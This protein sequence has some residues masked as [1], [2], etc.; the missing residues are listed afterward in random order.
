MRLFSNNHMNIKFISFPRWQRNKIDKYEV[1][2]SVT[3]S[4]HKVAE[5]IVPNLTLVI[6]KMQT[7]F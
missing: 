5:K 1:G 2:R 4:L 7:I 3:S 6:L